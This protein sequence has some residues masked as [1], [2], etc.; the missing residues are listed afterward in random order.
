MVN[1]TLIPVTETNPSCLGMSSCGHAFVTAS[2]TPATPAAAWLRVPT[3]GQVSL[4]DG[5]RITRS[6]AG[7]G[8]ASDWS[9]P[10]D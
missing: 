8:F 4:L 5:T 10:T 3:Q 1:M 9:P 2:T 6:M 7:F